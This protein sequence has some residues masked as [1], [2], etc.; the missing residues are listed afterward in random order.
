LKAEIKIITE[1]I[2]HPQPFEPKPS[3]SQSHIRKP[4]FRKENNELKVQQSISLQKSQ[5]PNQ[6][7]S[8]S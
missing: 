3:L 4:S 7:R 5:T 2:L 1:K 8:A 6:S